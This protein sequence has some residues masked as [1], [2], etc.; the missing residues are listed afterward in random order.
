MLPW[1]SAAS[2]A[3]EITD[4]GQ[5]ANQPPAS[6]GNMDEKRKMIVSRFRRAGL[7]GE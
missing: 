2:S 4:D 5:L 1:L 7:V 3:R 6:G